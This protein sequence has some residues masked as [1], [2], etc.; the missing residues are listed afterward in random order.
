LGLRQ[1]PGTYPGVY[2]A[3][4]PGSK[5]DSPFGYL[6]DEPASTITLTE[7]AK[8]S[9]MP[10][11]IATDLQVF[12]ARHPNV[13]HVSACVLSDKVELL[14]AMLEMGF[15]ITAYLPAWYLH[16]DARYDCVVLAR[17]NFSQTQD[18]R[19]FDQEMELMDDAYAQLASQLCRPSRPPLSNGW[20]R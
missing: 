5:H 15:E 1:M 9:V 8:A 14:R 19:R 6:L 4:S 20:F 13:A 2:F 12:V 16:Q 17:R 3:G 18:K 11:E 7:Y 10:R